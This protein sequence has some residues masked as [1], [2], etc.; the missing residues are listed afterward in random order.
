MFVE[1][2]DGW[3]SV[4]VGRRMDTEFYSSPKHQWKK[5]TRSLESGILAPVEPF[6]TCK[7]LSKSLDLP[8]WPVSLCVKGVGWTSWYE[9]PSCPDRFWFYDYASKRGPGC[10]PGD[11]Q[12]VFLAGNFISNYLASKDAF[13]CVDKHMIAL[14]SLRLKNHFPKKILHVIHVV[15]FVLLNFHFDLGSM[16]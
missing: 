15:F 16:Y 9:V 7:A 2:M 1:W 6:V 3:V 13:I 8:A 4:W 14:Y 12:H 10:K 11:R 5:Q